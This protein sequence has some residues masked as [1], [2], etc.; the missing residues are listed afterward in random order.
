M[1][2]L[3][4]LLRSAQLARRDGRE[5]DA[6]SLYSQ[7]VENCRRVEGERRAGA[8]RD[9]IEALKGLGQMERDLGRAAAAR[10]LYEEAVRL[11]RSQS[12]AHLLAHTVRHLGDLHQDL[13]NLSD[14]DRCYREAVALYRANQGTQPLDLA[15]ALRPFALLHESLGRDAETLWR[16]AKQLYETVGIIEGVVECARHLPPISAERSQ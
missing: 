5:A 3:S 10:P 9:L 16:E 7:A 2:K 1:H 12:D 15:N 6:H 4:A 11:C 13:G 8:T 14:A